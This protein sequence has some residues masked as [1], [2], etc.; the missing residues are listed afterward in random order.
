MWLR[1]K[2]ICKFT[3]RAELEKLAGPAKFQLEDRLA[4]YH[5]GGFV[6]YYSPMRFRV[7]GLQRVEYGQP[8]EYAVGMYH[9]SSDESLRLEMG[10]DRAATE[11]AAPIGEEVL[12]GG[13]TYSS[14]FRDARS[15]M[16]AHM[17]GLYQEGEVWRMVDGTMTLVNRYLSDE[18][19]Q[20]FFFG[21]SQKTKLGGFQFVFKEDEG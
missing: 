10:L 12:E 8:G 6:V 2:E 4:Y 1:M 3:P 21:K 13:I 14:T 20:L 7:E 11:D 19:Y 9:F 15:W 17:P 18:Q 5:G 16:A